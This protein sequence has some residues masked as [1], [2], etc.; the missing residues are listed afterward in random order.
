MLKKIILFV[1]YWQE[2]RFHLK[3]NSMKIKEKNKLKQLNKKSFGV[4]AKQHMD[5]KNRL[6]LVNFIRQVCIH[7]QN[8]LIYTIN[9]LNQLPQN[10]MG[11][12][13]IISIMILI[14]NIMTLIISIM[15]LIISIM[16]I[17]MNLI[18]SIMTPIIRPNNIQKIMSQMFMNRIY[19]F[20]K[21]LMTQ[22][23]RIHKFRVQI[24]LIREIIVL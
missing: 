7:C 17:I 12:I 11:Q 21:E 8:I 13:L 6:A 1:V 4:K 19:I 14:I 9:M 23:F 3:R 20:R 2:K 10:Q 16:I 24:C 15:T 18:I 22:I 5:I